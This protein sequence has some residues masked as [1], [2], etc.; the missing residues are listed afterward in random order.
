MAWRELEVVEDGGVRYAAIL[1]DGRPTDL[2]AER[3]DRPD[4]T[5]AL[6]LARVVRVD[7]V[8]GA[9]F[10]DLGRDRPG[11]LP[12]RKGA[13]PAAGRL[14]PVRVTG[15]PREGKGIEVTR[16]VALTSRT[17]VHLPYGPAVTASRRLPPAV[18]RAWRTRLSGGWIVRS[19]AAEAEEEAVLAEAARLEARWAGIAERVAAAA[20]PA[21]LA[22]PPDVGQRLLLDAVGV[23]EIR[24]ADDAVRRRWAPWLDTVAPDLSDR[25]SG[26]A[27]GFLDIL[28]AL[29]QPA[30]SLPG[31]GA[32][33]IE[34]TRAL[35]AIDVD[36]GA[37]RDPLRTNREAAAA[38]AREIR[39]RNLGGLI[40]VDFITL[41]D[42]AT[43]RRVL[44]DLREALADDPLNAQLGD[45]FTRFGLVEVARRRR[46][47]PLA[48]VVGP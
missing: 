20:G 25:L 15:E 30:V 21:M 38:A 27:A 28:P 41:G 44:A 48:C 4:L 43:R 39:L 7:R 5:D 34:A 10:L 37:A 29:L 17:L 13:T 14:L 16:D 33:T 9:A 18:R 24:I 23:A 22:P 12:L 3:C 19:A 42:G 2:A 32:I 46:G 1:V 11:F 26:E 31:G 45:G 35:T 40:V 36:A 47:R 6:F 8:A